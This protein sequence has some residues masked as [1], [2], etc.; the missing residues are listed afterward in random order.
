MVRVSVVSGVDDG[1][2]GVAREVG[3][4]G[5]GSVARERMTK[6]LWIRIKGGERFT[7][8]KMSFF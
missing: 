3:W 8:R 5:G 4:N 2:S 7:V 6:P 1:G